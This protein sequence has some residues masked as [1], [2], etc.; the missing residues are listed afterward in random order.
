MDNNRFIQVRRTFHMG[1]VYG[2]MRK[3]LMDHYWILHELLHIEA[4]V[5]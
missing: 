1:M 3:Q 4:L 5:S 2:D